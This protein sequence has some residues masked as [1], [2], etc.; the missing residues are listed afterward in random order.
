LMLF[1]AYSFIHATPAPEKKKECNGAYTIIEY[2]IGI[3]CNGD[4]VKLVKVHGIQ[5]LA[6]K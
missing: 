3:D 1:M 6:K 4:T 2:G 5:T